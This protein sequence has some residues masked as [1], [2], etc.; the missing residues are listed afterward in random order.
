[1]TSPD[2]H[3]VAV[4]WRDGAAT[5]RVRF[6]HAIAGSPRRLWIAERAFRFGSWVMGFG[7]T[8][9]RGDK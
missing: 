4:S 2:Q 3:V 8:L 5:Y 1:M 6:R 7:F 9:E